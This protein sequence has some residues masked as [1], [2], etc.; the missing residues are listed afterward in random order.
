MNVHSRL[1]HAQALESRFASRLGAALAEQ[2]QA[3]PHDVS[4]RLRVAREQAVARAVQQRAAKPA[5]KAASSAIVLSIGARAAALGSPVSWWQRAASAVPLVTLVLGLMLVNH[6]SEIEQVR[7]AAEIDAQL[8][9][10]QLPP[11]AYSDPG[12]AEFLHTSPP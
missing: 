5:A 11:D 6:V 8:L 7:A 12:F 2:A 10:D 9:A 4:E 1:Q 3:V